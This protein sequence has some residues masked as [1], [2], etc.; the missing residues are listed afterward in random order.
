ME[1]AIMVSVLRSANSTAKPYPYGA[2]QGRGMP[3]TASRGRASA[4]PQDQECLGTRVARALAAEQRLIPAG[5]EVY[6]EG[7]EGGD[8]YVVLEGWAILYQILED[9]RR[10]ILDFALPGSILGLGAA[11][12]AEMKHTAESLTDVKVAVVPRLRLGELFAREPKLAMRFVETMAGVL[13]SAYE[14]LT[15]A[16]RR[17]AREAVAHLLLRLAR[18]ATALRPGAPGTLLELPLTLEHIGDAL[19][20]TAVHVCRTLRGLRED[21]VLTYCKGRLRIQSPSR[22]A[23]AAG[24]VTEDVAGSNWRAA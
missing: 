9:G 17:T 11:A 4:V 6:A 14:S 1:D 24:A 10:Q 20:L 12:H 15:D 8:L 18:R 2:W 13:E 21:G 19:G 5:H 3:T 16:G 23:A 22:L 7:E